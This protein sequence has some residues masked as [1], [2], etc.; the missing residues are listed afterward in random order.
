MTAVLLIGMLVT[1]QAAPDPGALLYVSPQGMDCWSGKLAAPNADG[2]DGPFASV[3]R[4]RAAVRGLKAEQGGLQRPVT[5]WIRGGTYYLSETITF[6]SEDSGTKDCPVTYAAYPGEIPVL[7]GGKR[8]DDWRPYRGKIR[9]AFL[10]DVKSGKWYFRSLF[11]DGKRQTRARYPNL[12]PRDPYRKGFLYVRKGTERIAVQSIHN[13]GAWLEY[14]IAVPADGA[15]RLWICYAHGMKRYSGVA[16]M[17]GH[18]SV[19][20]DGG[21]AVPLLNLPDTGSFGNFRWAQS[22]VLTMPA[23]RHVLRWRNDKGGGLAIDAFVLCDDAEWKPTGAEIP[24]ADPGRHRLVVQAEDCRSADAPQMYVA[25]IGDDAA[26]EVGKDTLPYAPGTV[27]PS[28][29]LAPD[30]EVHVFP[31]RGCRTHKAITRLAKLDEAARTI[32]IAGPECTVPKVIGDRYFVE[33]ILEELD[34]PGEWNLDREAGLLYYWPQAEPL[35]KSVVL[36]PVLGTVFEFRGDAAGKELLTDVR[37]VGLTI[38]DTDYSPD[39]RCGGSAAQEKPGTVYLRGA[40]RCAVQNCRFL[41]NGRYAVSFVGGRENTITGN[42]MAFAAEG[43]IVLRSSAANVVSD[44]HIHDCGLVYKHVG[45]VYLEEAGAS[46]NVVAHNLIHD[47]SRYGISLKEAGAR[48]IIEYNEVYNC[49][50]ETYDTGGIEVTQNDRQ[51][52]SQS[53]IRYNRVHDTVGYSSLMGYGM[54]DSRGIYL[55]S[56]AGGYTVSH[57]IVYRNSAGGVFVQGGKDNRI[58]NNI[59]A[60][61]GGPQYLNPNFQQ[62][63]S[64]LEFTRNVVGYGSPQMSLMWVYSGG[65]KVTRFDDNV[66]FHPLGDLCYPVAN[67][68]AAWQRAGHDL[69]SVMADPQFVAPEKDDYSLQPGSPALKLGFEPIDAGQIGLLRKRC[70]CPRTPASWQWPGPAEAREQINNPSEKEQ[71]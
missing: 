62:H 44:N 39:D 68:L 61:N 30:A 9:C 32:V 52:R 27:K 45:G 71:P 67:R 65:E 38:R 57:N 21:A 35:E 69:H 31:G 43:G 58:F 3:A 49:N 20:L 22:A 48:N 11:T 12:D 60:N 33:N 15:Y 18:T 13:V 47:M 66:Y 19:A 51:F 42:D 16:D 55:D 70:S 59:I 41:N 26:M 6:T 24:Q 8:I 63:C 2:N 36:A 40:Q 5:V 14:E 34:S 50:L 29:A 46:D 7:C 4:A 56:F 25:L 10:P 37:L 64:G 23:G 1:A 17:G 54:F 53:V 28:W